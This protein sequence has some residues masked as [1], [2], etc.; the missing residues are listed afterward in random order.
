MPTLYK[1]LRKGGIPCNGGRGKYYLPT[2]GRVGRW[3]PKESPV[4]CWSGYHVCQWKYIHRWIDCAVPWAVDFDF[5][6]YVVETRGNFKSE[7]DKSVHAQVR[8]LRKVAEGKKAE[9]FEW[10]RINDL[11]K[12]RLPM[13]HLR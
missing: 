5:E 11:Q 2:K 10:Y 6:I 9:L 12:K 3:M 4:I 8:L 13:K 1:I 7:S